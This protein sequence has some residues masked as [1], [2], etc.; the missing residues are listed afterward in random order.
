MARVLPPVC[1]CYDAGS[2]DSRILCSLVYRSAVEYVMIARLYLSY[3]TGKE[4]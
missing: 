1:T 2:F 3:Y 4:K